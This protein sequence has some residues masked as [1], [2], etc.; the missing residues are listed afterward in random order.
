MDPRIEKLREIVRPRYENN[1]D[2]G[3]DFAHVERVVMSCKRIA[4]SVGADLSIV[5][6]AAYLHDVINVPKNHPDRAAASAKAA[7][8]ARGILRSVGYSEPDIARI[9]VTITEHS[10]S[11]GKKPSAIESAVLQDADRLDAVGAIGVMR[12]VSCGCKMGSRYYDDAEPFAKTRALDDKKNTLD[13]FYV[14]LLKLAEGMNTEIARI[15][16]ERRTE[17]MRSFLSQVG[18]EIEGTL[19]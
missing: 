8:E 3:H 1:G 6:P 5:L 2:P 19:T 18:R 11:L 4:E 16:A 10:Y 12:T 13:H 14:K 9:A 17:F 15:E 7:E